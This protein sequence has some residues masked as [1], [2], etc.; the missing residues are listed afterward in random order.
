MR[1]G[2]ALTTLAAAC[3]V[4]MPT[5]ATATR[6]TASGETA[7]TIKLGLAFHDQMLDLGAKG[8]SVGDERILADSLLDAKGRKVG[9][10]A[11]ACTFTSLAPPEAAC[12]VTFFLPEGQI[13][14]QFLNAPPPRK[15]AAIV[16]GT[17]AYRGAGGEAV[18][19]ERPN[20]TGTV[21]FQLTG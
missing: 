14:I 7:R 16:G 4:A 12:F 18:I 19:L 5:A 13:A 1:I 8:P 10:D 9:H 11:G 15:V 3:A 21:T 20:Q 17:G 2:L 6:S